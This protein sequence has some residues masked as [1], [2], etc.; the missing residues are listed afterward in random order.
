[1]V[2]RSSED[3][4]IKSSGNLHTNLQ[5]IFL[6][7]HEDLRK[8]FVEDVLKISKKTLNEIFLILRRR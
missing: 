2:R 1:M 5:K 3:L 6:R 4:L 7:S 8:I